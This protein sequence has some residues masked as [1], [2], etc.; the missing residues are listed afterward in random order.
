MITVGKDG[1]FF[2]TRSRCEAIEVEDREAVYRALAD[3]YYAPEVDQGLVIDLI[4]CLAVRGRSRSR[5][6][7]NSVSTWPW[8]CGT[9]GRLGDTRSDAWA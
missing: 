1:E 2:P 4:P 6:E 5:A 3:L 7:T 9:G 8:V